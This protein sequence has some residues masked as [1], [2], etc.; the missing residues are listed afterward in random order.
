VDI[1]LL[2]WRRGAYPLV[3]I[4]TTPSFL[5]RKDFLQCRKM[6]RSLGVSREFICLD[7]CPLALE[8][9][10]GLCFEKY[11]LLLQLILALV[12]H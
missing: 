4:T 3:G 11:F 7:I 8:F 12:L 9:K 10:A 1:L 5:W 6:G 2:K